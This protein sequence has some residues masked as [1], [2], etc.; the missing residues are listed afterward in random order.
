MFPSIHKYICTYLHSNSYICH[1]LFTD[2]S[3]VEEL[4]KKLKPNFETYSSALINFL[5]GEAKLEQYLQDN[6]PLRSL[7]VADAKDGLKEAKT[8]LL[9][10]IGD[11]AKQ[12]GVHLD[13]IIL[14]GKLNFA[15]ANYKEALEHYEKA[16]IDKL[17]E[18]MLPPRSI[19][20]LAEAFA[21]QAMCYEKVP[22]GS[23]SKNKI[24]ER[25]ATII[26][27]YEI[28]G[29]LTLL[30]LQVADRYVYNG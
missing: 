24:A 21:I 23:T 29:D 1:I 11:D 19:K 22:V 10:T 9:T 5:V 7:G 4:A 30:F 20:M 27:S 15:E 18:K 16:N 3:K 6:P 12:L 13:S 25:E 17:E 14:L 28:S 8:C 2:W 26:K